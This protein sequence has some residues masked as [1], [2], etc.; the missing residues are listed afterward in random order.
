[1]GAIALEPFADI[2]GVSIDTDSLKEH[3]GALSALRGRSIDQDVGY[4]TVGLRTGTI[5]HWR[6]TIVVLHA[7]AARKH[8][9]D[10]VTPEAALAASTGIRFTVTG[11]P[12]A[13][14]SALIDASLD[15]AI[16][17]GM[18]LG[19]SLGQNRL[20]PDRQRGQRPLHLAVLSRARA[21]GGTRFAL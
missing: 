20:R 9:F 18:T 15:F 1:M 11:V 12:L 7:S 5:W 16:G 17:P 19:A 10:G 14:D 2:A 3:G 13:E 8:A 21:C 4:S 6:E